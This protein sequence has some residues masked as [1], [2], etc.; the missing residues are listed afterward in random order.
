MIRVRT[1]LLMAATVLQSGCGT[2][3]VTSDPS[4]ATV[5]SRGK[6]GSPYADP[7]KA[8]LNTVRGVT[9]CA[10]KAYF[11]DVEYA[12]VKWPDGVTSETKGAQTFLNL[13]NLKFHFQKPGMP[14]ADAAPDDHLLR[15]TVS[16]V[17]HLSDGDRGLEPRSW[18]LVN[19]A[20]ADLVAYFLSEGEARTLTEKVNNALVETEYFAILSRPELKAI[21]EAQQFGRTDLC[22][23]TQCLVELGKVLSVQ[24]IVGGT[25]GKVG[26]TYSF[27]LRLVDVE[28]G[29]T[30][31]SVE[32]DCSGD[33]DQL[34]AVAR[35]L[36]R[37]LSRRYAER[38]M[39]RA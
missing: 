14:A 1:I 17:E 15:R 7:S 29:R 9:P 19:L 12:R 33:V 36:A 5:Y 34:L 2:I 27:T 3:R 8:A 30:E 35:S 24:K 18:D 11:S 4:G 26:S 39:K 10:Y 16:G 6:F 22:D 25:I 23:D 21:L 28:T 37:E 20:V 13:R 31:L 32:K 38:R